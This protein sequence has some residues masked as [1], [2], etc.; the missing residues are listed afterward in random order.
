MP[1]QPKHVGNLT[2][3]QKKKVCEWRAA[4]PHIS[5]RK[6]ALKA[7]WELALPKSPTQG[8]ICN[9][10]KRKETFLRAT[11]A[12]LQRRRTATLAHP[13]VDDALAKET[14]LRSRFD[15]K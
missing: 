8:T 3:Q 1:R 12:Q 13:A 11:D 2:F 7:Q 5:Q 15:A 10:L 9:I 14:P 6:L 4:H